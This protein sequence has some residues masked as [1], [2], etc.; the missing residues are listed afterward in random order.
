MAIDYNS[1]LLAIGFSGACLSIMLLGS[2]AIARTEG[3]ILT[4]AVGAAFIVAGIFAYDRYVLVPGRLIGVVSFAVLLAAFGILLG[5]GRQFRLNRAPWR[6]SAAGT[7]AACAAVLPFM[8]FGPTGLSFILFNIA[9]AALLLATAREYWL[10]RAEAPLPITGLVVFYVAMAISFTLCA[11]MLAMGGTLV[12]DQAP[13]NWAEN[14][15]VIVS[16]AG[17]SGVGALS[18]ALNQS[19]LARSHQLAS[20]TDGLTGLFNRRALFEKFGRGDVSPHVAFLLFD[21]DRFKKIN[22]RHGHAAGDE[23]LRRFAALM[24]A[25]L[26]SADFAVRVGGEEFLAVLPRS[27]PESATRVAERIRQRFAAEQVLWEETALHCT[28]S[29]GMV[30][31]GAEGASL[32][33]LLGIADAALYDAKRGGRNRLESRHLRL[34]S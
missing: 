30:I 18:L 23:V 21:L 6:T 1:L 5:A 25:E 27:T 7:A 17:L 8:V 15:N 34:A 26:R 24:R 11:A 16:I 20:L 32:D 29:A 19:R 13:K 12:L 3:F 9:S 31:A 28:V 22:D 14:V 4:W 10:A 2:W 33:R